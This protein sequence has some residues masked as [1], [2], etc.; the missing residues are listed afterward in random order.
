M[1]LT[2][3]VQH[4]ERL[5]ASAHPPSVMERLQRALHEAGLRLIGKGVH[6]IRSDADVALVSDDVQK[7]F[8]ELLSDGDLASLISGLE[9]ITAESPAR[10]YQHE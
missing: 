8:I 1:R 5:E 3:R 9:A 10:D 7:S 6:Q 4:L 2:K